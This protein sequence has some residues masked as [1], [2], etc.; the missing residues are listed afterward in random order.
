MPRRHQFFSNEAGNVALIF[1]LALLPVM[2]MVGSTIDYGRAS[3]ANTSL[4]DALDATALTL[5]RSASTL[6]PAQL[7][8]AATATF[9]SLYKKPG[10]TGIT[11]SAVLT[12]TGVPSLTVSATGNL[13][14][15]MMKLV[16]IEKMNLG[17]SSTVTWGTQRLRVALVL[18]NTGSMASDGKMTALKSASHDLLA[19][20]QGAANSA[21]DIYVSIIPFSKDVNVGTA[22]VGASWV[23]WDL[24]S[25]AQGSKPHSSWNGCVTDRDQNYDA[26]ATAPSASL[27]TEFPAEQYGACP[28]ALLPLSNNWT[29][30]NA[31]IDTMAPAGN[32]N[33][34]IGMQWGLQSLVGSA[35]LAIPAQ[36][37]PYS[38]KQ[39]VIL[40]TDGLNTQNRWSTN[41]TTID[42]RTLAACSNAKAAGIVVYTVQVNTGGDPVSAMLQQ[43]A[44]EPGNFSPIN[45]ASQIISTFD[46]IG[47]VLTAL[48]VSQ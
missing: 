17:G 24:W 47:N 31:L 29:A 1:G 9:L 28:V 18:D 30:L 5:S 19:K 4:Q 48:R 3:N 34:T 16:G 23:R 33:Q 27:S 35:P 37:A 7:N 42:N 22:N 45:S 25:A 21:G 15:A 26:D 41:Q 20:F 10:V 14:T 12:S 46:K 13:P 11:V 39:V 2:L 32:T 40:L 36:E 44:S 8:D 6:T 43:C 38:Y